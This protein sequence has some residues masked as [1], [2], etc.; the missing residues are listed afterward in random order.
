MHS[1][2]RVSA[3]GL[4]R[5]VAVL[6]DTRGRVTAEYA[7]T[8]PA[9]VAIVALCIG[10]IS[11]ATYQLRLTSAA[12]TIARAEARG[13]N[14]SDTAAVLPPGSSVTRRSIAGMLCVELTARPGVGVLEVIRLRSEA[15][16]LRVDQ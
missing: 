4:A 1:V 7:I 15:C 2:R 13:E 6:R 10:G 14:A 5:V 12:A 16:A 3:G 9:V 8:L 11:L